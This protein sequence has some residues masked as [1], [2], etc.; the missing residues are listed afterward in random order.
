MKIKLATIALS[1]LFLTGCL[2][3]MIDLAS[4]QNYQTKWDRQCLTLTQDVEL[5]Q[6]SKTD[7]FSKNFIKDKSSTRTPGKLKM[8]G[9]ISKRT[10]FEVAEVYDTYLHGTTG[11]WHLRVN[12]K[13]LDGSH[14]GLEVEIP[15]IYTRHPKPLFFTH[16]TQRI[17]FT[18]RENLQPNT[19]EF[20]PDFLAS[21][22]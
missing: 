22:S 20:N 12:L 16:S 17:P 21:C 4:S 9:I 8:Q 6:G 11:N 2:S 15:G 13:V 19:I 18:D 5:W 14:K 3:I 10:K 7:S 1:G